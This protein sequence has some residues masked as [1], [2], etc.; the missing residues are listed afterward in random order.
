MTCRE[1]LPVAL[2]DAEQTLRALV[3]HMRGA[4]AADAKFVGIHSGGAW[5]AERLAQTIA[6]AI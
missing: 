1:A 6:G 3:D 5:I 2:P 4:V